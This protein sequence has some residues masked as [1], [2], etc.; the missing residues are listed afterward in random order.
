MR[1][2]LPRHTRAQAHIDKTAATHAATVEA[3]GMG[4]VSCQGPQASGQAADGPKD[5][6][7]PPAIKIISVQDIDARNKVH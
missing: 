1:L 5:E 3:S 4:G 7:T 6:A 2:A